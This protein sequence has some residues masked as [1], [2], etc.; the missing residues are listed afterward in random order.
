MKKIVIPFLLL[1]MMGLMQACGGG[2]TDEAAAGEGTAG[3]GESS[4]AGYP[5]RPIEIIV[6]FGAGGGSD[7]FARAIAKELE[8]ILD[9]TVNIVNLEGAAGIHAADHVARAPADG[10]TIWSM[11]SNY[12]INLASGSTPHDLSTYKA[13]GRVQHDTMAFHALSDGRFADIDDLIAQAKE[14]P[15]EIMIGGTGSA[16][17][18]ELVVRQFEEA[19]GT[20]LNYIS[21]EGAGEMTAALLG[22]HI[23]VIAEEPG[24]AMGYLQEGTL[25]MLVAFA[26]APLEGFEDTPISTDIGIDVTDGQNRGF[27]VHADTPPELV[28][29][30]EEALEEAKERPDYKAYEEA[31]YLHLRDGWLNSEEF[32]KELENLTVTYGSILEGLQ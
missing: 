18:D 29:L 22:G 12:P 15:G 20:K 28:A 14:S 19:T 4:A 7:N 26:D 11:T 17:F 9:A 1:V 10:Y 31:N 24:P 13:I 16:G 6:G 23:D 3:E 5:E 2:S 32:M 21:Y 8:D 25:N 30:L 27:M